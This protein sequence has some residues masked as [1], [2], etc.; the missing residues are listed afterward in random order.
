MVLEQD[1]DLPFCWKCH[2]EFFIAGNIGFSGIF[3]FTK[4]A[5]R[6]YNFVEAC[7]FGKW[8]P[9]LS[10]FY[11]KNFPLKSSDQGWWCYWLGCGADQTDILEEREIAD[12]KLLKMTNNF[13]LLSLC[14]PLFNCF[15]NYVNICVFGTVFS[16]NHPS[17]FFFW[18]LLDLMCVEF[19]LLHST[20]CLIRLTFTFLYKFSEHAPIFK[21]GKTYT[22]TP[23]IKNLQVQIWRL[24]KKR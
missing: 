13:F 10:G 1:H 22:G 8:L 6:Y 11:F 21:Q 20:N 12:L 18:F 7:V 3:S 9:E 17:F 5:L 15:F 14:F 16:L 4:C 2:N 19:V 23:G 24:Q